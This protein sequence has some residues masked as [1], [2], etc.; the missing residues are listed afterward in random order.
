MKNEVLTPLNYSIIGASSED[1]DHPFFSL[2][3]EGN[4][5]NKEGWCSQKFCSYPQELIIQL[6]HPG[7]L[8]QLNIILHETKIP[9]KIDFYYFFPSKASDLKIDLNKIPFVKLGYITP[10]KNEKTNFKAREFKKIHID[11][12]VFYLKFVLHKNYLNLPNKYNQ[13]G[14]INI[15]CLGIIFDKKNINKLCPTYD[16]SIDYLNSQSNNEI[17]MQIPSTQNNKYKDKD[18]D[19][20]CLSKMKEI[21]VIYEE[22]VKKESY[23]NAKIFSELYQRVRLLAEKIKSLTDYKLKCIE[24]NDF[25]MCKKLKTD[26]D[27]IKEIVKGINVNYPIFDK[28]KISNS[29]NNLNNYNNLTGSNNTIVLDNDDN[30]DISKEISSIENLNINDTND[31]IDTIDKDKSLNNTNFNSNNNSEIGIIRNFNVD[32]SIDLTK[33]KE[34][35]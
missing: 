33:T 12:N 31:A 10:N 19:E 22:C 35:K 24:T 15:Q 28:S 29:G 32:K 7:R 11:Q 30:K 5:S 13:V 6:N 21:K 8:K 20:T 3:S 2:T 17:L 16:K 23:E 27:R 34:L 1:P 18:L 14:I 9:S 25:D 26:I 4:A